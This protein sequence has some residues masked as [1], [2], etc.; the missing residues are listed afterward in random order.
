MKGPGEPSA[1][2]DRPACVHQLFEDQVRR[3]PDAV[4]LEAGADEV[5]YDDLNRRANRL[6]R[7][8]REAGVRVGDIVG[9]H[10]LRSIDSVVA[11]LAVLKAGAAYLPLEADLPVR[12]RELMLAECGV[13]LVLT[14]APLRWTD[15][16]AAGLS[17]S[18]EAAAIAARPG[19]DLGLVIDPEN[20]M[21][22]PYTS[23]S[24]GRPKGTEVPH[25]GVVGFFRGAGY[26]DWSAGQKA[27]HHSAQSWDGHVLDIYPAL[28]S[29]GCVVIHPGS[30]LD[31]VDVA[32]LAR[33]RGV[34]VLLLPAAAF[35]VVVDVDPSLLRTVRWLL[36]GGE[37]MS[38][39]HVA[40]AMAALPETRIVNGY[41]PSECTV[42]AT[43]HTVGPRDLE[44]PSIPIGL[45]VGDRAVHI[46]DGSGLPVPDGD[47]GELYIGG[48]GVSRGYLGDRRLTAERFVPD[49]FAGTPGARLFRTGDLGRRGPHG[50]LEFLGRVD[51]QV[52]IRGFRVELGE[53]ESVLREQ[54][55]IRDAAVKVHGSAATGA[56]RLIGYVVPD[57]TPPVDPAGVRE[58]LRHRLPEAMVPTAIVVVDRFPLNHHGKVDRDRLPVPPVRPAAPASGY[59]EPRTEV[60][61]CLAG[62]W[63]ELFDL[64]QVGR[65]DD[66]FA[67]GGQSIVATRTVARIRQVFGADVKLRTLYDAPVLE[68]FA[69]AVENARP[70]APGGTPPLL[71]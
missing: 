4:A 11:M 31:T 63:R 67:L 30:V 43:A 48:P 17:L 42:Y 55:G 6:A 64:D 53:V 51:D 52:K 37:T 38:P 50:A 15:P 10:L 46:L 21:Y 58:A 56:A 29:G 18:G 9:I 68:Q 61:R 45:P 28:L 14:S 27:L 54:P 34:T 40:K 36:T 49:P 32:R 26:A 65:Q 8:L 1:G 3:T 35:N 7:H 47:R 69:A 24:T 23:G 44:S 13:R 5:R 39:G 70:P 62:I 2:A 41:G 71:Q 25:R 12:R 19:D 60:E 66:F 59:A 20:L 16:A 33:D 57:A 22:V